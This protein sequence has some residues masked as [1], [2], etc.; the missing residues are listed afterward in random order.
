MDYVDEVRMAAAGAGLYAEWLIENAPA[1]I[2]AEMMKA[3]AEALAHWTGFF[4]RL[5]RARGETEASGS[6][7]SAEDEAADTIAPPETSPPAKPF[8]TSSK[9]YWTPPAHQDRR[10][11][12]NRKAA[13]D[14]ASPQARNS[15]GKID[16]HE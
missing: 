13:S 16:L 4:S 14:V 9:Q 3:V 1:E 6:S 10:T 7:L 5:Q 8:S 15:E 2:D 12:R 11:S